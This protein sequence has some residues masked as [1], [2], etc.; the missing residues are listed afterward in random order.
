MRAGIAQRESGALL[1]ASEHQRLFQEH[2][3]R[4][5]PATQAPGRQSAV[6]EA[7]QHE[8]VRRLRCEWKFVGHEQVRIPQPLKKVWTRF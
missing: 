5:L 8:R 4:Q 7:E 1:V 2:R 6:P 3:F